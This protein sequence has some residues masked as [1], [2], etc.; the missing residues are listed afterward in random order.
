[1]TTTERLTLKQ[2]SAPAVEPITT[3]EAKTH[4]RID[5]ADEDNFIDDLI[6]AAREYVEDVS[7]RALVT[8]T[9]RMSL[10]AWPAGD[11]ILLPRP[12]LQSVM[13][14]VYI[15]SDGD[16]TTWSTDGYDVDTD[17]EP[18]RIVLAY[19][20]SWPSVTLRPTNPIQIIFVAGY[21]DAA[22]DV[23]QWAKKAMMLLLGHWYENREDTIPGT[24]IKGI[25]LGVESLIWANRNF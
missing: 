13:S 10:Q 24:I 11:E 9:W 14:V 23:P 17:G 12:P 19:G 21:G 15:D 4:L 6:T 8:Q 7:R 16:S 5:H 22:S 1:M 3:A 25:P 20:E 2:T 18:G